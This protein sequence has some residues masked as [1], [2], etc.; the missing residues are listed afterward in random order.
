MKIN[1]NS[2]TK[3]YDTHLLTEKNI[4]NHVERNE[5]SNSIS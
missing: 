5:E 2:D 3:G 1:T 4:R